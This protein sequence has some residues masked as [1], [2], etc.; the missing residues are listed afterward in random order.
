M[1]RFCC[2]LDTPKIENNATKCPKM[3]FDGCICPTICAFRDV[4][5]NKRTTVPWGTP[6]YWTM[7]SVWP[8]KNSRI[9]WQQWTREDR[10]SASISWFSRTLL[11]SIRQP[12]SVHLQSSQLNSNRQKVARNSFEKNSGFQSFL[13]CGDVENAFQECFSKIF[14]E[15]TEQSKAHIKSRWFWCR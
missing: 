2:V 10:V 6:V 5:N 12:S 13:H 11:I 3:R 15:R 9:S 4:K 14:F 1:W 8:K 7:S